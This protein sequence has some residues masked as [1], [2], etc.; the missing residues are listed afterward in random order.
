MTHSMGN[1]AY[2][3]MA[4]ELD[5]RGAS[6]ELFEKH[7][8]VAAD[9]RRD[10]FRDEYNPDAPRTQEEKAKEEQQKRISLKDEYDS[11][12]DHDISTCNYPVSKSGA[13]SVTA[14]VGIPVEECKLN[15]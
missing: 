8:M 14:G 4:M 5:E 12:G 15:G 11:D 1:W 2:Q 7:F 13:V 6:E 3:V 9:A 10:M